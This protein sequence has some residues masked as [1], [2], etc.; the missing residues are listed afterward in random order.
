M[1]QQG[2]V[3][4]KFSSISWTNFAVHGLH[5]SVEKILPVKS[6]PQSKFLLQI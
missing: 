6:I 1:L 5:V 3:M 4:S 2:C